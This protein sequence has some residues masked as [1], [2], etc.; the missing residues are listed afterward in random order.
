M[1]PINCNSNIQASSLIA[2]CCAFFLILMPPDLQ[3]LPTLILYFF[4]V[5]SFVLYL[6]IGVWSWT[7]RA[8]VR[9]CA[10]EYFKSQ[11]DQLTLC[12]KAETSVADPYP[13]LSFI[14]YPCIGVWSWTTKAML[15]GWGYF[16]PKI[17]KATMRK[18]RSFHLD[19]ESTLSFFPFQG[20]NLY[21]SQFLYF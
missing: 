5:F 1:D 16:Y 19:T 9:L 7:I 18:N 14:L 17:R 11:E 13:A 3:Q 2:A 20:E 21:G 10:W 12:A 6:C 4:F 15:C 8:V